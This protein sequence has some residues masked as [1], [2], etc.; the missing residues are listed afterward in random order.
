MADS[1]SAEPDSSA[2]AIYALLR[3]D[4]ESA[5]GSTYSRLVD[6]GD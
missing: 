6:D 2:P 3:T 4:L 1:T 5:R